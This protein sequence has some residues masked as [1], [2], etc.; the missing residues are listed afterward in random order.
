[1][2][3]TDWG[4]QETSFRRAEAWPHFYAG[5]DGLHDPRNHREISRLFVS[6]AGFE[7]RGCAQR[8]G[9]SVQGACSWL[10]PDRR[11][12]RFLRDF[13]WL[14]GLQNGHPWRLWL[15]GADL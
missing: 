10:G 12:L 9:G 8:I 4:P 1:M 3:P 15:E 13:R 5:F 7:V 11:V 6:L 14:R 2:C